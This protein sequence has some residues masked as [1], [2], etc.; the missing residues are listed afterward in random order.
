MMETLVLDALM[1]NEYELFSL[2]T[3]EQNRLFSCVLKKNYSSGFQKIPAENPPSILKLDLKKDIYLGPFR[4]LPKNF[5]R[6]ILNG[7]CLPNKKPMKSEG[8][9]DRHQI[10]L[11]MLSEFKRIN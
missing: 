5:L 7:S 8:K 1:I 10:S 9:G 4:N 2:R 11:L 6:T 3:S